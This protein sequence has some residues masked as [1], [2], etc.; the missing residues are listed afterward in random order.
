MVPLY[1]IIIAILAV[2]CLILWAESNKSKEITARIGKANDS[3]RD[4]LKSAKAAAD[5]D[6]VSK[7]A[8]L[9]S[10]KEAVDRAKADFVELDDK[11]TKIQQLVRDVELRNE[12]LEK[13]LIG[14]ERRV[15]DMQVLIE[16]A[17]KVDEELKKLKAN[18]VSLEDVESLVNALETA[19]IKANDVFT[20]AN[21]KANRIEA[22]VIREALIGA[23]KKLGG[24]G[25]N[26]ES[27]SRETLE[28][29]T[30]GIDFN[31]DVTHIAD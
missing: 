1:I 12:G 7:D 18:S 25:M 21:L 19:I 8:A 29:R 10:A 30:K 2:A 20:T 13:D 11:Y 26:V 9:R 17:A 5:M 4:Q 24:L 15:A 14:T 31:F 6:L 27:L 22:L 28:K 3:L 16:D 23:F